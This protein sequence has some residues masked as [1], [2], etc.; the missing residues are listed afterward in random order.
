M[1]LGAVCQVAVL[2]AADTDQTP[3]RAG[4]PEGLW[5]AARQEDSMPGLGLWAAAADVC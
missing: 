4:S 2:G 5:R 3:L 1:L